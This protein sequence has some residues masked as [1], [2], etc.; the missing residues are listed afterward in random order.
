MHTKYKSGPIKDLETFSHGAKGLLNFGEAPHTGTR[1]EIEVKWFTI[2]DLAATSS[3]DFTEDATA[4]FNACDSA[5][6]GAGGG[7]ITQIAAQ[8]WQIS[9]TGSPTSM[10]FDSTNPTPSNPDVHMVPDHDQKMI[11]L[12]PQDGETIKV[13]PDSNG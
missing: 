13:T 3:A 10:S 6:G 9:V 11:K 4:T 2:K 12:T 5:E 8:V 1:D 7:S